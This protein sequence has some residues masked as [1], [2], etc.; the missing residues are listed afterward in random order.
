M[1]EAHGLLATTVL[2]VAA[3]TDNSGRR[4]STGETTQTCGFN[5]K[6]IQL[7]FKSHFVF[8]ISDP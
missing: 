6:N 5:N 7:I 3:A 4:D 1:R 2:R 8:A